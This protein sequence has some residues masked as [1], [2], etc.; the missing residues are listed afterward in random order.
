MN[1]DEKCGVVFKVYITLLNAFFSSVPNGGLTTFGSIL[2][3]SFGF[4]AFHFEL[5]SG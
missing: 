3:K 5:T 2:Y 1:V 4:S